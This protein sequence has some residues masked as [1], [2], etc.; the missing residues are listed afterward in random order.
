MK[1]PGHTERQERIRHA[2]TT[3]IDALR[4]VDM[5]MLDEAILGC[6]V[7]TAFLAPLTSESKVLGLS[8]TMGGGS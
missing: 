3:L 5:G 1:K 8:K 7:A 4:L 6:F 2:R